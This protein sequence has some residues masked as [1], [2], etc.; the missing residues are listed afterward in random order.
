MMCGRSASPKRILFLLLIS[1]FLLAYLFAPT[2]AELA[3]HV[4]YLGNTARYRKSHTNGGQPDASTVPRLLCFAG[5][6]NTV[7]R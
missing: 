6:A 5:R 4:A 1:L 2:V 3:T 7:Y